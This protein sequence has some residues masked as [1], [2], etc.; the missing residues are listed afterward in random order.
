MKLLVFTTQRELRQFAASHPQ[1]LLPKLLTIGDFLDRAILSDYAFVDEELRNY[2][3]YQACKS[4]DLAKLGI[5]ENFEKFLQASETLYSFLKEM[6]LERVDFATLMMSDTYAEYSE[7]IA[8]LQEIRQNYKKLLHAK[9]FTDII[10]LDE[11]QINHK[12]F[13]QF[14]D[15]TIKL[16][17]YLTKF[18]REIIEQIKVPLAIDFWA[19]RFNLPLA[20]KMFGIEEPGHYIIKNGKVEKVQDDN[21]ILQTLAY[22]SFPKRIEQCNYIFAKIEEFV[23][24]GIDPQNIVVIVPQAD[25][26]EYLESFDRLNNLNFSMGE[27]FIY[28]PLYRKLEALYKYLY[29][30]EEEFAKKLRQEEVEEFRNITNWHDLKEFIFAHA[31]DKEKRLIEEDL[32]RFERMLD[33]IDLSFEAILH[34]LLRRLQNLRFDDIRGGKVTVMEVLESRGTQFDGV[35]IAD[36]NEGVVPKLSQEDTFL[37]STTRRHAKLPTTAEKKSLQKHYYYTLLATAK[38]AVVSFVKNEESDA[39]RFL[40]ELPFE[41]REEKLSYSSVLYRFSKAPHVYEK[42]ETF[43]KPVKLSPTMLEILLKCPLRY[44]LSYHQGIRDNEK[45]YQGIAIHRAIEE[46]IKRTPRSEEEYFTFIWEALLKGT[47][48]QERYNL[49]VDWYQRLKKFATADFR[50]LRGKIR[51]EVKASRELDGIVLEARVDRLIEHNGKIFIYDYKTNNT[52]NYL[53]HYLKDT[54][55]LQ[56]EFYSYIWQSDEVYFW[57]LR[58]TKLQK[59]DTKESR[60]LLKEALERVECITRKS[61]D[62]AYCRYCQFKFG[63]RGE[64]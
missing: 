62:I 43:P 17:G 7:H 55:K 28:S 32:F 45:G 42:I 57:D 50:N 34:L 52:R 29:L 30:Q 15:I 64:V 58:N 47:S 4:V 35:I 27:S 61:D 51:T 37:N 39:S 44:Y 12:Y 14:E 54:A 1:K 23:Q 63:C 49:S 21:P 33:H 48:R 25:F 38:R 46:A 40:W 26:K 19:S 22:K 31:N 53:N 56:A 59:V 24:N 10:V 6:F 60:S 2:Y 9:G 18:D 41:K 16:A 11:Y 3:F 8:I 36:F 20:R 5:D 13:D